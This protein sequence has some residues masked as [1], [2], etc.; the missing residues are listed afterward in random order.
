M[1]FFSRKKRDILFDSG[2]EL[3]FSL[4]L[5]YCEKLKMLVPEVIE[6][7]CNYVSHN[8]EKYKPCY[9]IIED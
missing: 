5:F 6:D 2:M 9:H 1:F 3:I 8:N 4:F 7:Q